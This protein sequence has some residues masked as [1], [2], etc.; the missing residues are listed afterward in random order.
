MT[1]CLLLLFFVQLLH[2]AQPVKIDA[3]LLPKD[4]QETL[5]RSFELLKVEQQIGFLQHESARLAIEKQ[6]AQKQI[7]ELSK[8][9]ELL[10]VLVA[11]RLK[12]QS[13]L[14]K[15]R[16]GEFILNTNLN[17]LNTQMKV[18]KNMNS[19]DYQLFREYKQTLTLLQETTANLNE[20][21]LL[22]EKNIAA[23]ET[24]I[25]EIEKLED[26]EK[27]ILAQK[28][29]EAFLL[30]KGSLT[31]PLEGKLLQ[32]YGQINDQF[33]QYYI[34]NTGDLWSVKPRTQVR[35]I[36]PGVVIF[37]DALA[38]WRDT[39]IVQHNDQYY[40]VYAGIDSDLSVGQTVSNAQIIGHSKSNL[41]YFE[42]R[43]GTQPINSKK[44]FK[45]SP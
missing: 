13:R 44:W 28:N 22:L 15:A 11:K 9:Q 40:S 31:R 23:Y 21:Q 25:K 17:Q 34:L 39:L 16:W 32:S 19:H 45:E 2:A 37:R 27:G 35:S 12:S 43:H 7:L 24:Q 33:G 4:D 29:P 41:F 42:L 8:K 38:R 36:G 18:L 30:R 10:K 1:K 26:I 20:T 6:E 3:S 14:Q 5:K